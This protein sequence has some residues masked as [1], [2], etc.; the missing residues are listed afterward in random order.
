[1]SKYGVFSGPYFPVFGLN[2]ERYI[3]R[4]SKFNQYGDSVRMRENTDQKILR[5]WTHFTQWLGGDLEP[6]YNLSVVGFLCFL[7]NVLSMIVV[8]HYFQSR[9]C[10][11]FFKF[12]HFS[13]RLRKDFFCSYV[14]GQFGLASLSGT[15]L[16][17]LTAGHQ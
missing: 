1:M 9:S 7:Q 8:Q 5:I 16:I 11:D 17:S 10:T 4:F 13:M 12:A 15:S 6:I 3:W 14:K 2:M